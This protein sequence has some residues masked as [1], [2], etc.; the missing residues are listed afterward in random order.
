MIKIPAGMV[1]LQGETIQLIRIVDTRAGGEPMG[2]LE[3]RSPSF[4]PLS[5]NQLFIYQ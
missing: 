2:S 1:Q 3:V 5:N 4:I